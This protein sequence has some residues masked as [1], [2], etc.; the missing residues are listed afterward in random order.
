[1]NGYIPVL[2][3][4][5]IPLWILYENEIRFHSYTKALN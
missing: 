3:A 5:M 4:V 2:V 1:M